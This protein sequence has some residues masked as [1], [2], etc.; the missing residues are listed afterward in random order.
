MTSFSL[1]DRKWRRHLNSLGL[2]S[3]LAMDPINVILSCNELLYH[4]IF[5]TLTHL[6]QYQQC[7]FSAFQHCHHLQQE[8]IVYNTGLEVWTL[9]HGKTGLV[10]KKE[11]EMRWEMRKWNM[12]NIWQGQRPCRQPWEWFNHKSMNGQSSSKKRLPTYNQVKI[13][14]Q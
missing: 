3:P 13:S 4:T 10:Q 2:T 12:C 5:R 14:L 6:R 1:L 11:Q 7:H 9:K 8:K